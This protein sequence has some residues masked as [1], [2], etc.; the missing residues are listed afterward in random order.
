M[1]PKMTAGMVGMGM[2]FDDTYRPFFE[3]VARQGLYDRRFGDLDVQLVAVATKT[4][5]R[6]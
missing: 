5:S 2:I 1:R 6:A 4:G 3:A